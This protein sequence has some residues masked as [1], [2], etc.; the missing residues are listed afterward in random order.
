M[1]S[2]V[3][4]DNKETDILFLGEGPTQ[5]QDFTLSVKRFVLSRHYN[6]SNSFLFVNVIKIHQFKAKD[7]EIKGYTL[8]LG[9]ISKDFIINNMKKKTGLKGR[10]KSFSF[11]FNP[12]FK[13][14]I[15]M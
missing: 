4:I 8:C 9:N 3:Y 2:S 6:G 10:V 15:D 5:G 1:S 7:F 13:I 12:I 11:D 14:F